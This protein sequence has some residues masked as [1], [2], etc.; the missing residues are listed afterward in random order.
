[1]EVS[2]VFGYSGLQA[3]SKRKSSNTGHDE[4]RKKGEVKAEEQLAE[5]H[6][7]M[8]LCVQEAEVIMGCLG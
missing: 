8:R 7:R 1:M 4:V 6:G 2:N 3:K 5:T